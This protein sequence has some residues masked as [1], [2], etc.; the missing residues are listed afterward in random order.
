M[1]SKERGDVL[2]TNPLY[3]LA[4]IRI[5]TLK[6]DTFLFKL[7]LQK[8]QIRY[9]TRKPPEL[10]SWRR[11]AGSTSQSPAAMCWSLLL[12]DWSSTGDVKWRTNLTFITFSV[13]MPLGDLFFFLLVNWP[14]FRWMPWEKTTL[15]MPYLNFTGIFSWLGYAY[16]LK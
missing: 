7:P 5:L 11:G 8:C 9:A 3:I 14:A 4:K 2:Y 16:G 12:P 6:S 10:C 15:I 13:A 1:I